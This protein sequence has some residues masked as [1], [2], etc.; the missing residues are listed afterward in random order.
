M[1]AP[2]SRKIGNRIQAELLSWLPGSPDGRSGT[3]VIALGRRKDRQSE[4]VG[5]SIVWLG[6]VPG[7]PKNVLVEVGAG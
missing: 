3:A 4:F 5:A 2:G 1:L 6:D 7:G